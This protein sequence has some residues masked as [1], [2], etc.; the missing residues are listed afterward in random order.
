[1]AAKNKILIQRLD[2]F[3]LMFAFYLSG[4]FFYDEL[5]VLIPPRFPIL[6]DVAFRIVGISYVGYLVG[7]WSVKIS[8]NYGLN[9]ST[10][11]TTNYKYNVIVS[12]LFFVCTGLSLLFYNLNGFPILTI[13]SRASELKLALTSG[14]SYGLTR[15]VYVLLPLVSLYSV[16]I[17]LKR[18][19]STR[20][21]LLVAV[22]TLLI[23]FIGLFKGH[24]ILYLISLAIVYDK[25]RK[26]IK[27]GFRVFTFAIGVGLIAT[28]PIFL[29]EMQDFGE[30]LLYMFNR[31]TLYSWEG[32]NLIVYKDLEPDFASQFQAFLSASH[33]DSPDIILGRLYTSR[34]DASFAVVPTLFG[35]A[36]RNGGIL[37]CFL[38]FFL[39][40]LVVQKVINSMVFTKNSLNFVVLTMF[41]FQL[42]KMMMVGNIFHDIR[43]PMLSLLIGFTLIRVSETLVKTIDK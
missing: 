12:L 29:T 9:S 39:L 32:L 23:L 30:A 16:A 2:L 20:L 41:Y 34:S 27:L 19:S 31:L 43:G 10:S 25:I 1:M 22:C 37:F 42:L 6:D 36:F 35:F 3:N 33:Y 14:R 17:I 8:T 40:G 28:I 38:M 21:Y 15:I 18:K 7:K 26:R 4:I 11:A 5:P 24:I 13:G